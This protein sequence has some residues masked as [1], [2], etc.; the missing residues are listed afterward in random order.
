MDENREV[1]MIDPAYDFD[2][3]FAQLGLPHDEKSIID[4]L[5]THSIPDG[6]YIYHASFWTPAQASLLYEALA[7][8][9]HWAIVADQLATLLT[10]KK[11]YA[12]TLSPTH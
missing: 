8:D 7:D 11:S 3:F 9:A 12:I 1:P 4:F 6:V 10:Q 2:I 5:N